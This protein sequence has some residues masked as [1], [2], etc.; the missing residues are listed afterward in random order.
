MIS[1]FHNPPEEDYLYEQGLHNIFDLPKSQELKDTD[2]LSVL[3]SRKTQNPLL[4]KIKT[5]ALYTT[6][7]L[8]GLSIAVPLSLFLNIVI[9]FNSKRIQRGIES[10]PDLIFLHL[11]KKATV[12]EKYQNII[13]DIYIAKELP[14]PFDLELQYLRHKRVSLIILKRL[15]QDNRINVPT[16]PERSLRMAKQLLEYTSKNKELKV[17]HFLV[18]MAH[19][20][21]IAYFLKH[22]DYSFKHL[23]EYLMKEN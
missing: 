13:T 12:N 11:K 16:T 14:Q 3:K 9:Y 6:L 17:L 23:D 2:I 19:A 5:Y 1:S 20:T 8:V 4:R 21:Q 7:G 18:G 15:K 22:P 10:D